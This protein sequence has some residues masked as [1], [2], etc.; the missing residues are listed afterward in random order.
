MVTNNRP[1]RWLFLALSC[2]V[3][4]GTISVGQQADVDLVALMGKTRAEVR[5]V[6]PGTENNL[7][8]WHGWR[9]VYLTFNGKRRLVTVTLE[10][11][12][13]MTEVQAEVAIRG[14]KIV[15]DRAK[16]FAAPIV[17]G[18][19][20]MNGPVRTVNYQWENGRVTEIGVFFNM[21]WN[22]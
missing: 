19:R 12:R 2:A 9:N 1:E 17:H 15:P 11:P 7:A 14:F 10:P 8:N 6:F 22:E 5:R 13:P 20:G 21:D 16:Y 4:L 18:Y 3:L